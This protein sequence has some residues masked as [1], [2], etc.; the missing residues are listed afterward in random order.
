MRIEKVKL[1]SAE[2]VARFKSNIYGKGSEKKQLSINY[3]ADNT[4]Q[5]IEWHREYKAI[6][7]MKR[8]ENAVAQQKLAQSRQDEHNQIVF[9]IKEELKTHYCQCG[10]PMHYIPRY[11]FAGCTN[12]R[13]Q[14][15]KHD[16]Y[17]FRDFEYKP[18][19][20]EDFAKDYQFPSTYLNDFKQHYN[21]AFVMSSILYEFL[22]E[23]NNE[24]PHANIN[25][26]VYNTGV[27]NALRSKTEEMIAKSIIRNKFKTVK[28]Q[29]HFSLELNGVYSVRVIDLLA[30]NEN[31]V[32]VFEQKK[33]EHLC[34]FEKMELYRR[35]VEIFL[36]QRKD[37]RVVKS[38]FI[39]YDQEETSNEKCLTLN[40]L[41]NEF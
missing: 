22:F 32:F 8:F 15:Y 29:V 34:D 33:H 16:T 4:K 41:K 12:Y 9:E 35:I 14:N 23:I 21:I 27:R 19:N 3:C 17:N 40:Q 28:E 26:N 25:T 7:L 10:S 39:I 37:N 36:R 18:L 38:Y 31:E 1:M 2:E 6:H 5:I 24:T 13:N 30:S 20:Y 11:G